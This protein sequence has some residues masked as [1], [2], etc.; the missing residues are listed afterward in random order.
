M[1]RI[2]LKATEDMSLPLGG[3]KALRASTADCTLRVVGSETDEIRVHAV[4]TVRAATEAAARAFLEQM[5]VERRRDGDRWIVEAIWPKPRP[6]DVES[7]GI[8]LDIQ[9]PRSIDLEALTSNGSVEA[10]G[11]AHA[12][13]GTRNGQIATRE[14]AAALQARTRNGAVHVE[15][16]AGPVEV[17]T[18]HGR[19]EVRR[20]QSEVTARTSNGSIHLE[21][22]A[23]VVE[24]KTENARIEIRQARDWITAQT[25]NGAI[26]IE[27]SPGPIEART[28]SGSIGIRRARHAVYA[29]T[30]DGRIEVELDEPEASV[31]AELLTSNSSIDLTV[32]RSLSARLVADTAN[33]RISMEPAEN[34]QFAGG[35]THLE[36]V[37]GAGEGSVRL[38][39]SNG[40]IRIRLID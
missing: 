21:E 14:I 38:R 15:D 8:S 39:T 3:V 9:V 31:D 40:A 27:D 23:G 36:T 26:Q 10:S 30:S 25:C 6:H 12:R 7:A 16:C 24:V 37:L 5:T 2:E 13:L 34:V 11:V 35:P 32:P 1:K 33:A 4:K 18:E 28:S 29:R 17:Q 20:A 19:I 22:C